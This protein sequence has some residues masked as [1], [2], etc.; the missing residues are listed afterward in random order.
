[1][2]IERKKRLRLSQPHILVM[3]GPVTVEYQRKNKKWY[4]TALEFD[5]V[6]IGT[7]RQKAFNELQ[8]VVNLYLME[9]INSKGPID[10]LIPTPQ[11]ERKGNDVEKY[12]VAVQIRKQGRIPGIPVVIQDIR[13]LRRKR[14]RICGLTLIP[15]VA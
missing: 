10:F 7:S 1:M 4:C 11:T 3:E 15:A 6:G 2:S 13:S 12:Q 9:A 8:K 14:D 5:L